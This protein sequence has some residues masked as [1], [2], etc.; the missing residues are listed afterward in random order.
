V[1]EVRPDLTAEQSWQ[2]LQSVKRHYDATVGMN[3]QTLES[4]AEDL[5]GDAPDADKDEDDLQ[6]MLTEFEKPNQPTKG[7]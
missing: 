1:Q 5:F 3:W 6:D 2:V 4:A 7:E